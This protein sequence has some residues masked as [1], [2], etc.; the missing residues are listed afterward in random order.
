MGL[1]HLA[2]RVGNE[3]ALT[4]IFVRVSGWPG[5]KVEFAPENLGPAPKRHTTVYEPGGI[6]FEFDHDRTHRVPE[7]RF[8][9]PAAIR[10]PRA[11]GFLPLSRLTR[12]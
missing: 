1:H 4:D 8:D 9:S 11:P 5:V 7:P 2:L 3:E 12:A 6:R 10:P